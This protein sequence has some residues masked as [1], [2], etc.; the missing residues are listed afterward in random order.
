MN[1]KKVETICVFLG[2]FLLIGAFILS[3]NE[4]S[5]IG[6]ICIIIGICSAAVRL[7]LGIFGSAIDASIS[8][9][10]KKEYSRQSINNQPAE[11]SDAI[12]DAKIKKYI[13]PRAEQGIASM[14]DQKRLIPSLIKLVPRLSI[15]KN[16]PAFEQVDEGKMDDAHGIG[17]LIKVTESIL[18]QI[19]VS[20]Y[21]NKWQSLDNDTL[22][23]AY[24]LLD[25][26]LH[27]LKNSAPGIRTARYI[28]SKVL[29]ERLPQIEIEEQRRSTQERY[30][31]EHPRCNKCNKPYLTDEM[32]YVDDRWLCHQCFQAQYGANSYKK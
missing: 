5:V 14:V 4:S 15:L 3:K 16:H 13:L 8:K 20:A 25:F 10:A 30:N 6:I 11:G 32:H 29:I 24:M 1:R 28:L 12:I 26:Y 23:N 7:V 27:P 17:E 2:M 9:S 31:A 21:F 22:L 18:R 19:D